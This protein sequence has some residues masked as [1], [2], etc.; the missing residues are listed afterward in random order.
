[1]EKKGLVVV[2]WR[3]FEVFRSHFI[4]NTFPLDRN[5]LKAL[6]KPQVAEGCSGIHFMELV[7]KPCSITL[8]LPRTEHLEA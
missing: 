1:M 4:S 3:G 6:E 7:R 8:S 5:P 2:A